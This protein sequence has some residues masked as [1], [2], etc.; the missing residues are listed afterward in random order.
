[1]LQWFDQA[2]ECLSKIEEEYPHATHPDRDRMREQFDRI[3]AVFEDILEEWLVLEEQFASLLQTHPDLIAEEEEVGEE[4]WLDEQVVRNFRQGQGYY[5]LR[6]FTEARPFFDRVVDEEPEFLLGR[7]YLGLSDFQEGRWDDAH[8]QFRLVAETAEHPRFSAFAHHMMGCVHIQQNHDS[9]AVRQF[10]KSLSHDSENRDTWFNMGACHYRMGEY[11]EAVPYFYHAIHLD[12]DDWE[13]MLYL[14]YCFKKVRQWDSVLYWRIAAYEKTNSPDVIESIARDFDE[15]GD[16]KRALHWYRKLVM[17]DPKR[18]SAYHG[19]S[20]NLWL[21]K[22]PQ[23]AMLWLQK[24]LTLAPE[25]RELLFTYVWYQLQQ[26]D[27]QRV[28]RVLKQLPEEMGNH[29]LWLVLRSRLYTYSGE[30]AEA[31][32]TAREVIRYSDPLC[33]SLGHFQLGRILLAKEQS[34]QAACHFQQAGQLS[35]GWTDPLFFEGLCHLAEGK[36]DGTRRCWEQIP[37]S[38]GKP[39]FGE[40]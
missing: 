12:E 8:R 34:A 33:Q 15:A 18:I 4:F 25:D 39:A 36:V 6:M 9:L 7:V 26:G 13:S 40:D 2:K 5:D 24:G 35:P 11:G 32:H 1:M 29:P 28:Q 31:E 3:R 21:M 19:I 14:S 38:A 22:Q 30:F 17:K 16:V 20:W 27:V 23:E 37:L 10:E